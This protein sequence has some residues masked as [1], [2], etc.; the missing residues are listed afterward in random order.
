MQCCTPFSWMLEP[1]QSFY[2]PLAYVK[3][4]QMLKY[5]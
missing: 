2:F 1:P 5:Q 3:F 4:C